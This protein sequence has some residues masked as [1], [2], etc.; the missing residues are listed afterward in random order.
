MIEEIKELYA[1]LKNKGEFARVAG[2]KFKK[3][4]NTI[5]GHWI[6]NGTIPLDRQKDMVRLLKKQLTKEKRFLKS[7]RS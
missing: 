7:L 5:K 3:N 2:V 1:Q 6:S 4:P